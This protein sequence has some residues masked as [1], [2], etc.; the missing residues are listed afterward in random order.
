MTPRSP[1]PEEYPEEYPE[2]EKYTL[3]DLR[4]ERLVESDRRS[5][6]W[7]AELVD[8]LLKQGRETGDIPAKLP[9]DPSESEKEDEEEKSFFSVL[10]L[11]VAPSS[12]VHVFINRNGKLVGYIV[13][14][15]DV[16]YKGNDV[17][18]CI[19]NAFEV[20]P[21]FRRRNVGRSIM[22]WL[23]DACTLKNGLENIMVEPKFESGSFFNKIPGFKYHKHGRFQSAHV[24]DTRSK[25]PPSIGSVPKPVRQ[26]FFSFLSLFASNCLFHSSKSTNGLIPPHLS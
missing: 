7:K 3:N 17:S 15:A 10:D 25:H 16:D 5:N 11:V 23:I 4:V 22:Q 26:V 18:L 6:Y 19:I 12:H 1:D 2:P 24:C 20:L 9:L 13:L 14:T 8:Y 21:E